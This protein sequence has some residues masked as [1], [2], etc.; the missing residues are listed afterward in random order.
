MSA[1][2]D[3]ITVLITRDGMGQAEP[4]LSRKLV[5]TWFG[6]LDLENRLPR[7]ICFYAD[8]VKLVCQGSPV[9][10]EL[11]ALQEK[12][13]DLIACGTCLNF[14]GLGRKL[15]A[16]REGTMKDIVAAQWDVAK[17]ITL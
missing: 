16:G 5:A 9:L 10:D 2:T 8:G 12:G 14:Y 3:D 6:L 11:Q 17:V 1:K 15:Q 7:A 4:A 13:V